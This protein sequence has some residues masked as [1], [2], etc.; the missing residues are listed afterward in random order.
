MSRRRPE[1]YKTILVESFRS[2]EP[3]HRYPIEIRP[4][5]NQAYPTTLLVSCPMAMRNEDEYPIGT[6][7]RIRAT[8]RND[9]GNRRPSLYSS[10]KWPFEV[11]PRLSDWSIVQRLYRK[12][13]KAPRAPF[14]PR[15]NRLDAPSEH[16]VYVVFDPKQS[17]THVGRTVRGDKGLRRRL[18]NHLRGKSSFARLFLTAQGV[19]LRDGYTFSCLVVPESR[20]RALL[21]AY[22]VG[23]LCPLH[24]GLGEI[25]LDR[26]SNRGA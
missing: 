8:L 21:E 26:P 5:P 1:D 6:V 12:L 17:V 4:R 20:H 2:S 22:A 16:G 13:L 15:G 19:D 18:A 23:R 14:P 24:L 11:V 9:Q 7:F 10:Y 3:G 25:E